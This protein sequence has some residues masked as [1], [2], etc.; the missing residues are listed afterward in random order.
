MKKI[1]V[2]D[3]YL[4]RQ[5]LPIFFVAIS[6]FVFLFLLLDLFSNL[7]R[8][9][10]NEVPISTML[11]ITFFYIPKSISFAMPMSLLFA[12][13]Y[14]LGDLY[15]RNELTSV[16]STG[17]PLWRFSM[18]FVAVGLIASIFSFFLDDRIVIPTLK[19]K[20]EL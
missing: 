3:I 16:F 8:Y 19:K 15:A 20:N 18:P 2:L 12:A 14:T 17:I 10:N 9:L 13:A 6:L 1:M 7:I 5:F 11:K 4:L